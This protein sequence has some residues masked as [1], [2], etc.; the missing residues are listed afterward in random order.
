MSP[1]KA[2]GIPWASVFGNH[3]D[4]KASGSEKPDKLDPDKYAEEYDVDPL[5]IFSIIKAESGFDSQIVS[6]KGAIGLMQLMETTAEEI[7]EDLEVEYKK[8]ETL[9]NPEMNIKLG[10]NYYAQLLKIYDNDNDNVVEE[11][12]LRFCWCRR[13][14]D[15]ASY[16]YQCT[17]L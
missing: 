6:K 2:R 12:D 13:R 8:G 16:S 7:A 17:R 3:D 5:I 15:D 11:S 9:Y 10:V 1:T 14:N 4:A